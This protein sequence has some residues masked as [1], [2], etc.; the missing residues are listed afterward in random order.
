MSE[1]ATE[2]KLHLDDFL[3]IV[4]LL[5]A[6]EPEPVTATEWTVDSPFGTATVYLTSAFY[7]RGGLEI[8]ANVTF[9]VPH[10]GSGKP[11]DVKASCRLGDD[12]RASFD[13][14][15][16][17]A[18]LAGSDAAPRGIYLNNRGRTRFVSDAI[19]ALR[20]DKAFRAALDASITPE[21]II[22]FWTFSLTENVQLWSGKLRASSTEARERAGTLM[23]RK[24]ALD[25]I[26]QAEDVSAAERIMVESGIG[27]G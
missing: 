18:G 20:D 12:Y 25:A 19:K 22:A 23:K 5:N 11:W 16:I 27:R 1:Q 24:A 3:S 4:E 13:H 7:W 6:P 26:R 9:K 14:P 10:P 2:T 15:V 8:N 21:R 17:L